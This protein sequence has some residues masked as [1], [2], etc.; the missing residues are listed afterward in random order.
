MEPTPKKIHH[1]TLEA[2][3][4]R[5][6]ML[7]ET[8]KSP[9]NTQTEAVVSS[10]QISPNDMVEVPNSFIDEMRQ[11]DAENQ[12]MIQALADKLAQVENKQTEQSDGK[13]KDVV[14]KEYTG[15]RKVSYHLFTR[16]SEDGT[17]FI[18]IVNYSS[19]KK[20][21]AR[22]GLTYKN[23]Y[24]HIEDNQIVLLTL[25]DGTKEKVE[26]LYLAEC[27]VSEMQFPKYLEDAE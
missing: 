24:G 13:Q 26:P 5:E 17:E 16:T 15:P 14:K 7:A 21:N 3:K 8:G 19:M 27:E 22:S 6:A 10:D 25:A 1:K 11:R 12:K 4:R 18:P 23:Q 9:E 20:D 2:Q